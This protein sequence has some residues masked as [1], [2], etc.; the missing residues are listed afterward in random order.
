MAKEGEM[1]R[2]WW[3]RRVV[4]L[5]LGLLLAMAGSPAS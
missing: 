3:P 5:L 1:K 4:I 2:I